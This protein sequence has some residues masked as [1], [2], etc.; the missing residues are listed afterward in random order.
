MVRTGKKGDLEDKKDNFFQTEKKKNQQAKEAVY[1]QRCNP[2]PMVCWYLPMPPDNM[3]TSSKI[4]PGISIPG[5]LKSGTVAVLCDSCDPLGGSQKAELEQEQPGRARGSCWA[6][7]GSHRSCTRQMPPQPALLQNGWD[8]S[9]LRIVLIRT[10]ISLIPCFFS[11]LVF[12]EYQ[13]P[14]LFLPLAICFSAHPFVSSF[15]S[16][17]NWL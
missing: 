12:Q 11:P 8:H 9:S 6:H 10:L 13:I 15:G 16:R 17:C 3:S 14:N 7:L 2:S 4:P 1:T 5:M